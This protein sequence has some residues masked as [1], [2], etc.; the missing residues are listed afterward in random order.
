[1]VVF[2]NENEFLGLKNVQISRQNAHNFWN[3][4]IYFQLKSF[5]VWSKL[6]TDFG[7]LLISITIFA[8]LARDRKWSHEKLRENQG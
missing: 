5:C 7:R 2:Y 1:M 4:A 8:N 6:N 3:R